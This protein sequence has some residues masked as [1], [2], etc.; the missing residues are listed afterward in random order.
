MRTQIR[1]S[2]LVILAI[3]ATS[4]AISQ[5]SKS[6]QS[7]QWEKLISQLLDHPAPAPPMLKS[8]ADAMGDL[9]KMVEEI[10]E[11]AQEPGDSASPRALIRYWELQERRETGKQP[12]EQMRWKLLES[13][14]QNEH[15]DCSE[16]RDYFPDTLVAHQ[17]VNAYLEDTSAPVSKADSAYVPLDAAERKRR[18]DGYR[19]WLMRH[20]NY[21][22]DELIQAAR[23]VASSGYQLKNQANLEA[24]VRLDWS[25]A[26]PIL[27]N[28]LN[29]EP[30]VQSYALKQLYLHA[31]EIRETG[32]ADAMRR[33]LLEIVSNPQTSEYARREAYD[34]L[35]QREWPGRDEWFSALLM[36]GNLLSRKNGLFD[37]DTLAKPIQNAPESW[38]PLLSQLVASGERTVHDNAALILATVALRK[39]NRG[40]L[41][42]L[43]PWLKDLTWVATDDDFYRRQV[44]EAA[45]NLQLPEAVPGLLWIIQNENNYTQNQ[46]VAAL[47]KYRN[48]QIVT[49]LIPALRAVIWREQMT[50]ASGELAKLL[51]SHGGLSDV[52][53][54][55]SLEALATESKPNLDP[56][57][58]QRGLE[59]SWVPHFV[60]HENH[61]ASAWMGHALIEQY[62]YGSPYSYIAN[63]SV[64]TESVAAGLIAR[65]KALRTERPDVASGLWAI[66]RA[67]EFPIV[68]AELAEGIVKADVDLATILIALERRQQIATIA[69]ATLR[70]MLRQ[71]GYALGIASILLDDHDNARVVLGSS[72]RQAQ[73]ALL[74]CARVMRIALP[75]D[76]AGKLLTSPDKQLALAA[77][78]YLESEDSP[79]ARQLILAQHPTEA[80]ILG[81]APDFDPK[82]KYRQE[83][84]NWEDLLRE[85]VKRGEVEELFGAMEGHFSDAGGPD[86][87][88]LAIQVRGQ[89]ASVCRWQDPARKECRD[90]TEDELSALRD[91]FTEVRFDE[92]PPLEVLGSGYGGTA[93]EFV[94]LDKHGGRRVY[95][96]NLDMLHSESHGWGMQQ[97]TPHNKVNQFFARL[98]ATGEYELRYALKEKIPDL[99]VVLADDRR[100][101]SFVCGQNSEVR[102]L[103]KE[104]TEYDAHFKWK[105]VND[106][107]VGSEAPQPPICPIVDAREDLPEAMRK[108]AVY[109]FPLWKTQTKDG[110]VRSM[111]WNEQHALWFSKA[112]SEPRLLTTESEQPEVVTPDGRWLIAVKRNRDA[113]SDLLRVDLKTGATTKID[114]AGWVYPIVIEPLTGRIVIPTLRDNRKIYE[115]KLYTPA[116]KTLETGVGEFEPL[117][118]QNNRSL[119]PIT[120]SANEFWAAI[121]DSDAKKTR[122]GRYDARQFKFTSLMELPDIAF[123]STS[124]WV[125]EKGN[126]LYI[127][128]NGHLLR[129][130]FPRK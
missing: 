130:P 15:L 34:A 77:E 59:K 83:W 93:Q 17:R 84:I 103:V 71:R 38:N 29:A 53:I 73:M 5:I 4:I 58:I 57:D 94:R 108:G 65:V 39:P 75:I 69:G 87:Y 40:A 92:L 25:A 122:V 68:Y 125:D 28:Y 36:Q 37:K 66:V 78:R 91:L 51:A 119:Q 21:F 120:G 106:G 31:V 82:R 7:G 46:A 116:T 123:T 18:K 41:L 32:E 47:A 107:K 26:K 118:H 22:R 97:Q 52:E 76:L 1:I 124:M 74:A 12:S 100:P 126:W 27:E 104:G 9:H 98:R 2:L 50:Y 48:P 56:A 127:A 23:A 14:L 70:P 85:S 44:I 55:S 63:K 54:L 35:T 43:L 129:L 105:A 114:V 121:P 101:V 72:D 128:Y 64:F 111:T 115:V 30:F 20:S 8:V 3:V 42:P 86:W 95:A 88:M 33:Q 67:L 96:T 45:G 117:K 109:A 49:P 99:E 6:R 81:G 62:N 61:S 112:G 11:Q 90:L 110:I 24:L 16:I 102:A 113:D 89:Q 60:Q 80:L 19:Q 10:G 13:C 79:K